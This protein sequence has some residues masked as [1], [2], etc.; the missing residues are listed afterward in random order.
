MRPLTPRQLDTVACIRAHW[1]AHGQAPSYQ[2]IGAALGIGET[3]AFYGVK[4]LVAAGA[5][6]RGV[7]HAD[8][9]LRLTPE[10]ESLFVPEPV[11]AWFEPH[12]TATSVTLSRTHL[13]AMPVEWQR[14]FVACLTELEARTP[15]V[16]Q[17]KELTC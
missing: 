13:E 11:R 6:S 15:P 14:R 17:D 3:G 4:R 2:E 16:D 5:L 8:R 1:Q 12:T 10:A 9:S 7:R